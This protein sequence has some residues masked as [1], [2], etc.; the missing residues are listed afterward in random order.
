MFCVL[1]TEDTTFGGRSSRVD[2]TIEWVL[3]FGWVE[4]ETWSDQHPKL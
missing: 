2:D 1:A 3:T 4:F